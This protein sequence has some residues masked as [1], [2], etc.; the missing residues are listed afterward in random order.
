[1]LVL[2]VS[3][4]FQDKLNQLSNLDYLWI[5]IINLGHFPFIYIIICNIQFQV[6]SFSCYAAWPEN[7]LLYIWIVFFFSM[8]MIFWLKWFLIYD[9][10]CKTRLYSVQTYGRITWYKNDIYYN[11]NQRVSH[12]RTQK[13]I[14]IFESYFV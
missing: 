4:C 14:Y 1:M 5:F 9:N 10:T 3:S 11:C 2:R 12:S 7:L 13:C 6:G 8:I